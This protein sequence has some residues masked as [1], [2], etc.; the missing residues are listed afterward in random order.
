[1]RRGSH[2]SI[3]DQELGPADAKAQEQQASKSSLIEFISDSPRAER[4]GTDSEI[5]FVVAWSGQQFTP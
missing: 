4:C 5:D 1:M 2:G 3:E